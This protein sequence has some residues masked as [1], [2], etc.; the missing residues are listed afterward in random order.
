MKS[1][2][3]ADEAQALRQS[4]PPGAFKQ[5]FAN[6]AFI[7]CLA[8]VSAQ[9]LE[10]QAM[11]DASTPPAAPSFAKPNTMPPLRHLPPLP[12][13]G[14]PTRQRR[15]RRRCLRP[16]QFA[17]AFSRA[18]LQN[19]QLDILRAAAHRLDSDLQAH[20]AK[21]Q[22]VIDLYRKQAKAA[23]AEGKP[24]PPAPPVIHQLESERS[25]ILIHHYTNLRAS[26]G[27]DVSKQLDAYLAYEFAPLIKLK[28]MAAPTAPAVAQAGN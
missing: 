23:L 5:A 7:A 21:A 14:D 20:K 6:A 2:A 22:I 18:G 12:L 15:H 24:L 11:Q 4:G 3:P 27:P 28:K 26:L 10:G 8:I 17:Q 1:K 19:P 25:A 16:Y 13:L 9:I